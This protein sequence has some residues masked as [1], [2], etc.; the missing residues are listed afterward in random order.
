MVLPDPQRRPGGGP[1]YSPEAEDSFNTLSSLDSSH[2][3]RPARSV[4]TASYSS[5]SHTPRS[6]RSSISSDFSS[7]TSSSTT[8]QPRPSRLFFKGG[9]NPDLAALAPFLQATY[10]REAEFY[11]HLAPQLRAAGVRLPESYFAGVDT[12]SG[13]GVVVLEDLAARGY[14]FGR[15]ERPMSVDQVRAGV[16]QLAQL[17]AATWSGRRGNDEYPW[18]EKQQGGSLR[19]IIRE[20]L[21]PGPLRCRRA[22]EHGGP[23]GGRFKEHEALLLD[24]ERMLG[25]F[26]VLWSYDCSPSSAAFQS[27]VHG[28]PHIGNTYATAAGVPGFLDWQTL[29]RGNGFHDV[30]YFVASALTVEDRRAY[31]GDIVR[32]N[33]EALHRQGGPH[34]E[35]EDAWLQYRRHLLHG[36]VLCLAQAGM[37]SQENIWILTKR[38]V[39]AILDHSVMRLLE[40]SAET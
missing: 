7:S 21:K 30:A 36:Y 9:L 2:L 18:L 19:D 4:S 34:L 40:G 26:E 6:S 24:R 17:H 22:P 13:Q 11:H 8:I 33:M 39:T 23:D 32:A 27:I 3:S 5:S 29:A 10:R 14:T 1:P 38:Y 35:W 37:Q 12:T 15:P 16:E 31:E 25:A 28:D 20:L